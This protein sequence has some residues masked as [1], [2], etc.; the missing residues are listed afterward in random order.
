MPFRF[1]ISARIKFSELQLQL[2]LTNKDKLKFIVRYLRIY[3]YFYYLILRA[4]AFTRVHLPRLPVRLDGTGTDGGE[5]ME[6]VE[7]AASHQR[8]L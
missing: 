3:F 8:G 7:A 2:L 4:K 5:R 1:L 6:G